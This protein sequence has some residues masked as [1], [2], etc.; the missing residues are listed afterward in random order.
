MPPIPKDALRG[1]LS[2][3]MAFQ[4][5][6]LNDLQRSVMKIR[7][8]P[9]EQLFRRFPRMVRDV[10]KQC[11][12]EVE[13]V[14]QR[15][16]HRSGQESAGRNRRAAY[17]SGSKCHQPWH[18]ESPRNVFA[19]ERRPAA[20]FISPPIITATRS[21]SK[22][23]DD[24]RGIDSQKVKAKAIEKAGTAEE[25]D[26]MGESEILALVFRPGFS[27][28]EKI[29]EVSGRGVGMDVVQNV[30]HRLKGRWNRHSCRARARR[31]A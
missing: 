24:G 28:A 27:T 12:K 7:M 3:A 15:P 21:S 11:G 29:T 19:A 26:R 2:D 4:S 10:A 1:R 22:I 6:V 13:L 20:P 8:V 17:P 25:A 18:R 23:S 16:G 14:M 9:V 5:R 31:S 30:L